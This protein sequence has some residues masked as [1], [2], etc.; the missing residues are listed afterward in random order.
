MTSKLSRLVVYC[1]K[2][3]RQAKTDV[4][5]VFFKRF[6]VVFFLLS[7]F[8]GLLAFPQAE[9]L[10]HQKFKIK[11]QPSPY[12]QFTSFLNHLPI[13]IFPNQMKL[14]IPNLLGSPLLYYK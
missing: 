14:S 3:Q 4:L 10:K 2:N 11:V 12:S 9:K 13:Q 5:F 1:R 6:F 8:S 7:A